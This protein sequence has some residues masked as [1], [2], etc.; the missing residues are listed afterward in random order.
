MNPL[1]ES[2][3]SAFEAV[4]NLG[5]RTFQQIPSDEAFRWTPDPESNCVGVLIQHLHG[6]M[7]S[8]WTDFLTTDGEKEWRDRDGEFILNSKRTR[9]DYLQLWE[10]GWKIF[11]DTFQELTPED[12]DKGVTIR[13]QAQSALEAILRQLS[14]YSYHVGQIV[15][16][17]KIQKPAG[18]ETLSIAKGK[19][20]EY[21][22]TKKD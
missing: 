14:H 20:K 7:L 3:L 21:K 2:I 15:L 4:K 6:N 12:L 19:S 10:E 18:W 1:L 8:R 16:L 13:G 11:F 17:A 22:P 5:D 9:E